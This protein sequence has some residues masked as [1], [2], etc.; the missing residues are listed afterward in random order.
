M[1]SKAQRGLER[2]EEQHF[3]YPEL[4][5][6]HCKFSTVQFLCCDQIDRQIEDDTEV[7]WSEGV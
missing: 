1:A 7:C 4:T 3:C 2:K 5:V 6:Y